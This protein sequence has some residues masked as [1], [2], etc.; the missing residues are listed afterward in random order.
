MVE[1]ERKKTRKEFKEELGDEYWLYMNEKIVRWIKNISLIIVLCI[2]GSSFL[3][4][5]LY[6][7]SNTIFV[8]LMSISLMIF[9]IGIFT[10]I[11]SLKQHGKVV[12]KWNKFI[13]KQ[14]L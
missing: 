7:S 13:D 8:E 9:G 12:I 2:F 3:Y 10:S 5:F 6:I 4:V 1:K 14:K 11:F